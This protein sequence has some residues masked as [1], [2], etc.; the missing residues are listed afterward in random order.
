MIILDSEDFG[1]HIKKLRS[2]AKEKCELQRFVLDND[3][4]YVKK[5]GRQRGHRPPKP[6]YQQWWMT[7]AIR[8]VVLME[9]IKQY[10]ITKSPKLVCP[11]T[12]FKYISKFL[13]S[14]WE[15]IIP[16]FLIVRIWVKRLIHTKHLS[17]NCFLDC[18][19]SVWRENEST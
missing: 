16:S 11:R 15:T 3:N 4:R 1:D 9:L 18:V 6:A 19:A 13:P 5:I 8:W 7:T 10:H 17:R 14:S 12:E 2:I